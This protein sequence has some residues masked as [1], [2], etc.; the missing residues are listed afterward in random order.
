[1]ESLLK[2]FRSSGSKSRRVAT[3]LLIIA[4]ATSTATAQLNYITN[5]TKDNNIYTNLN[6]QFPNTGPGTPGSGIGTPNSS[7]LFDPT[8]VG[9]YA[10]GY[11]AGSDLVSPANS[12]DFKITSDAAGHDFE[13]IGSVGGS[14]LTVT[15]GLNGVSDVY[16]LM[17]AYDGAQFDITFNG[18]GGVSQTFDNIDLPDFNQGTSINDISPGNYYDQ[19]VFRTVDTGAG[20]T[21]NSSYGAYGSYD[22]TQV[23]FKLDSALQGQEL[24]SFTISYTGYDDLLLGVTANG[25]PASSVPDTASTLPL[26]G[27]ALAGLTALRRRFAKYTL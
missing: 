27:G 10:P 20:G 5:F 13:Q 2:I 7:F 15:A 9:A 6:Q 12:V 19:T 3:T 18:T 21:G 22:L 17:G 26:L 16:L 14:P 8:T 24:T 23:T 1:M 11:T 25:T 4:G